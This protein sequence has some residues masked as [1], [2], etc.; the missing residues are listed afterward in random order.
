M[1]TSIKNF[2]IK[3]GATIGNVIIDAASNTIYANSGSVQT[4]N[5]KVSTYANLGNV[6]NVY[7]GGGSSGAVLS[8]DGTGNLTWSS[9]PGV[10]EI[11]NGNSN[12]SVPVASG[13]IY[14]N[15]NAGSDYQWIFDTTGN[16]TAPASGTAN[17][18]NLVTA[19]YANFANDANV[20]GN[21]FAGNANI[22]TDIIVGGNA[23]VTGNVSANNANLTTDI[24]IGGNANVTSNVNAGN[25]NV[26]TLLTTGNAN[27][28]TDLAVGGNANV[29]SNIN[30]GNANITTLLTTG[31]ANVTLDLTV[32]GNA[33]VTSN[34]N[35]GNANVTTLLTTG[36]ANVTSQLN[37]G[38]ANV[39]SQLNTGNANV[40]NNL[41]T[42]NANVTANLVAANANI[43][44]F[45]TS[46]NA[47][48]TIIT[49]GNIYANAGNIV[50]NTLGGTLNVQSNAQPNITSVGT[51]TSLLVS[52]NIQSNSDV[53]ANT[54]SS[55]SGPITVTTTTN[56]DI[57][58][59][60]DGTGNVDVANTYITN[61]K[62]PYNPQDAATK[63]Y[64]DVTAQGLL[65][66]ASCEYATA[67]ALPA[68]T[69]NNGASGVGATLTGNVNGVLTVD[70][71]TLSVGERILV[72][73]ETGGNQPY[74]GIYSVTATGSAGSPYILTRTNDFDS[75][76]PSGEI[77][78]AF[79]FIIAGTT[80]AN[81]GW[82]CT[83]QPPVTLGTTPITFTQFSAAGEYTAGTGI[84][85][86]GTVISIAN[87]SVS[88]GSYGGGDVVATFTVND[89]G[90]L[91]NASN[92]YITANA[93]NLTGNTLASSIVTSSLTS[94][95]TL[96]NLEVTG[97]ITSDTGYVLANYIGQT[98]T[99]LYGNGISISN[100]AGA[101]V[102]GNVANANLAGYVTQN[103][104]SNITSVGTLTSLS[105]TG[106]ITSSTG[107][108]TAGNI[109]SGSTY[110]IGNGAAISGITGA[111]VTGN[112]A[113]ANLAG[114]VTQNA[115]S[116]ITSLGTLANLAV[117]IGP[118]DFSTSSNVDLGNI[119]NVHILG[120]Q[121]GQYLQT[122]GSGS[123]SWSTISQSSISNGSSNVS[124]PS[125]N[126]PVV[127]SV[128]G[129][130]NIVNVTTAG[131]N[132][133]GSLIV[134]NAGTGNITSDNANIIGTLTAGNANVTANLTAANANVTTLLTAGNANVTVQLN[135]GNANV[136]GNLVA[137]T[138]NVTGNANVGNL[139][140]GTGTI[141]GTGNI[142]SGNANVGNLLI[143]NFANISTNVFVG[144]SSSNVA[145]ANGNANLTGNL[146]VGNSSS[147]V[148]VT[149]DGNITLTGNVN[150][151][152]V[153]F[154]GGAISNR[155]NVS[156]STTPTMIDQFSPSA[157]RTAKYVISASSANGYQSVETLLV[158]DGASSAYITIYGSICTN[159]TADIVDITANISGVTGNVTLYA[160]ANSSVVTTA[161]VNVV[162]T[163]IKT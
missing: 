27:V 85:I 22:T 58:L 66:K 115:Q 69:Y 129:A 155:S 150:T 92:T 20:Q 50:A 134:A 33:N 42:G 1:S 163:Y 28:T 84:S 101:N 160:T 128:N 78:G 15:A 26:T 123:L 73:N 39:T 24:I 47:N 45:L 118:V 29:T 110:L 102:S 100:I 56:G 97:N 9:S 55:V 77:P 79:T 138:A 103:S 40:T 38:N 135:A 75:Q 86:N 146:F 96:G 61:L 127:I 48:I 62:D 126:G 137:N 44:S 64:V 119:S 68:Y 59:H 4:A 116:N 21:L 8:T 162:A 157:F 83:T 120:G 19:N 7:I 109:G 125:T 91:T 141:T 16:F 107:N 30:A 31:N 121:S 2:V 46:A 74:N 99:Q 95:G 90:Q 156:V 114:Y 35:A 143:S 82:V 89:Q 12:V 5:L 104:Q 72:K 136:T 113:N 49:A 149:N 70:G 11:Q 153:A 140:F 108:I 57:N 71:G 139:G 94:V 10:T 106:D 130:S 34:V 152:Y 161:N 67:A 60:P 124:I 145:I 32:G 6:G 81:T 148:S 98:T 51:L 132:V 151:D 154:A 13:N 159:D 65:P 14:I 158:Q 53:L 76:S 25:A 36:N 147:N 37:A 3:N 93:A 63:N 105:V 17:L 131:A 142:V 133:N 117:A 122:D 112:V 18:G 80:N 88:A 41:V 87:T 54:V 43:T 144:N 23:N 52:G 111:N